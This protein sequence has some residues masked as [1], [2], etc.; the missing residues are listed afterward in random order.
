MYA[1][2]EENK[3]KK[4]HAGDA[5]DADASGAQ[6]FFFLKEHTPFK[7]K[8]FLKYSYNWGSVTVQQLDWLH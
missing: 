8:V 5:G 7:K 4:Q 2:E 6:D 3:T 1:W